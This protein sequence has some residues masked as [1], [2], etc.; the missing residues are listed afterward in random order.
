MKTR[1]RWKSLVQN[2]CDKKMAWN[3][4]HEINKCEYDRNISSRQKEIINHIWDHI[5][6]N[7]KDNV[8]YAR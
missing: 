6:N 4:V 7:Y 2:K 5:L 1:S 8:E 3:I